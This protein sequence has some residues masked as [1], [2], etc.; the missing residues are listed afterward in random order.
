MTKL[1]RPVKGELVLDMMDLIGL[2][3]GRRLASDEG[4]IVKGTCE[5]SLN[6]S[7]DIEF[8]R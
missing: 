4:G 3:C 6:L 5:Y 1:A 2:G 8:T 7:H